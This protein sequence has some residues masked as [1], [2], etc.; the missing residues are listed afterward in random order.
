MNHTPKIHIIENEKNGKK[1]KRIVTDYGDVSMNQCEYQ[2]LVPKWVR[3]IESVIPYLKMEEKTKIQ[4]AY[5]LTHLSFIIHFQE[6]DYPIS[7]FEKWNCIYIYDFHP[8]YASF[9]EKNKKIG[10]IN[11][12]HTL[13]LLV[14]LLQ[15]SLLSFS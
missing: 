5:S 2:N 15:S 9:L 11:D 1:E 8:I 13:H 7:F 6:K 12:Y 10:D 3:F 14:S 4:F